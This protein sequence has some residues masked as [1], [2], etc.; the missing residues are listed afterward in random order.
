MRIG[1][2]ICAALGLL[3]LSCQAPAPAP[4]TPA[5][6][7]TFLGSQTLEVEAFWEPS[8]GLGKELLAPSL[9]LAEQKPV[10]PKRV[11]KS[12]EFEAFLPPKSAKLGDVWALP[13][14]PVERLL[15]QF[16]PSATAK[17]NIPGSGAFAALRARSPER[18]EVVLRL[19]GQFEVAHETFLTPA[20][21]AGRVVINRRQKRVEFLS[22]LVPTEK[23]SNFGIERWV[24]PYLAGVGFLPRMELVGGSLS[25]SKWEEALE[26]PDVERTLSQL[27]YPCQAI[28]WV[29]LDQVL[30][31]AGKE[32]KPIF[33]VVLEGVLDDQSC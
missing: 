1:L 33:A 19:H 17:L 14:A 12:S 31:K 30:A 16:H 32:K 23:V 22:L 25:E 13:N 27:F 26:L 29:P 6:P 28:N 8:V 18:F 7:K 24:E 15:Q 10:I 2:I 3:V 5:P 21:F 9:P 11:Y 4:S 20:Q